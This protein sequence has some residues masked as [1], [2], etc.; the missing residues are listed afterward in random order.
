MGSIRFTIGR[1]ILV[2]LCLIVGALPT[3]F[4]YAE[5]EDGNIFNVG[6]F[7]MLL[8]AIVISFLVFASLRIHLG[9]GFQSAVLGVI[10]SYVTLF[11]VLFL[12]ALFSGGAAEFVM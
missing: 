5:S 10:G 8:I 1:L 7:V 3:H 12:L 4:L 6:L 11:S 9:T 2:N